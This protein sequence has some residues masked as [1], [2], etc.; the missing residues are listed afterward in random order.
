MRLSEQLVETWRADGAVA[1]VDQYHAL[2]ERYYGR[3]AYDFG[4][5]SLSQAGGAMLEAGDFDGAIALLSINQSHFPDSA[6]A[7]LNLGAAYSSAGRNEQAIAAYEAA[8]VIDPENEAAT[9]RL[10]ELRER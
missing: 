6:N 2:R 5:P 3:G 4:E 10:D 9:T 1:A 8:L 7:W